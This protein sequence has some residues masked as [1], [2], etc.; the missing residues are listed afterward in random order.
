MELHPISHYAHELKRDLPPSVFEPARSRLAWLP[1]HLAIIAI[2]TTAIATGW[3]GWPIAL[4]MVPVIGHSFAGLAFLAHETLHGATVRTRWLRSVVGWIGFLPFAV[5]PRF[6]VAWHNKVHHG[7]T[8][9]AGVDPDAYPTLAEYRKNRFVRVVTDHLSL[10]RWRWSGFLSLLIG[11]SI[12]SAQ[13]L[14]QAPR[15]VRMS[16][17]EHWR[18]IG[19]SAFGVGLWTALALLI[20]GSAF[21][22]A[23]VLPLIVAN[24]LIMSFIL[25]NHSLSPLTEINDP[26]VNSLTVT[27]PRLFDWTTLGFGYHVEHHLFPSM[28]SRHAPRLRQ[29]ILERWPERYQSMPLLRA[30]A[31]VTRT[32]RVYKGA[33]VLVDP[34]SGQEWPTL[35]PRSSI[36]SSGA[37]LA[38]PMGGAQPSL[39]TAIVY[40]LCATGELPHV[41]VVDSI[42]VRP[43]DLATFVKARLFE[44]P[45]GSRASRGRGGNE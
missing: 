24:V 36:V 42:R 27:V 9:K 25:T 37:S 7:H 33:T 2:A 22:F 30:L 11:F 10:A 12:Q 20:G 4:L 23:F 45:S 34:R 1:M 5:S 13:V 28:S 14:V 19:E 35:A 21:V 39:S 29:A 17:R 8:G 16:R 44:N 26:L 3:G 43:N 31:R 18:A 38:L 6:W 15:L 41:R 40:S 32:A